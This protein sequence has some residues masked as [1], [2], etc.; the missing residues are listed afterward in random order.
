MRAIKSMRMSPGVGVTL[1]R[2]Q[3]AGRQQQ[4]AM[5]KVDLDAR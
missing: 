4:Q 5:A 2:E 1:C 3:K